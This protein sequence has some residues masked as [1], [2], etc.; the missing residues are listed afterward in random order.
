MEKI[1]KYNLE[2]TAGPQFVE[3]PQDS[4]VLSVQNQHGNFAMWARVNTGEEK[5]QT[6]TFRIFGTGHELQEEYKTY[7][8]TVQMGDFVW[9]V[10]E[11]NN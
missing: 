8:G 6:R 11:L 10:L 3:M 4:K 2:L 7:I 9:H 1:Y 5:K